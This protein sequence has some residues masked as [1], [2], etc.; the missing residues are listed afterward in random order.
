MFI[1]KILPVFKKGSGVN[2]SMED[3]YHG[4]DALRGFAMIM[5]IVIHG[6]LAYM[7]LSEVWWPSDEKSS[8]SIAVIFAFIHL[9]RMPLFFVLAGFFAKLVITRKSITAWWKNRLIHIGLP[10]FIFSFLMSLL[11]PWILAYGMGGEL[12]LFHSWAGQPFHLWFLYHLLL[13]AFITFIFRIPYILGVKFIYPVMTRFKML[14]KLL[15]AGS[16]LPVG[17]ILISTIVNLKTGGELISN[18]LGS[19]IYFLFGYILY[20]DKQLL[21]SMKSYWSY[22]LVTAFVICA[23]YLLCSIYGIHL[24]QNAAEKQLFYLIIYCLNITSTVFFIYGFIGLAERRFGTYNPKLRFIADSS[25]WMYLIHLP[26]IMIITILTFQLSIPVELKW[27][28][29]ITLA[30]MICLFTYYYLVRFTVISILL[31][32]KKYDRE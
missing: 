1:V 24:A 2:S 31:S 15:F 16:V 18:P 29:S 6:S 14:S 21:E 10:L 7:P 13:F 4:L 9:W 25:Y 3:R 20:E 28:L 32:G 26:I 30:T 11:M 22:Y 23:S 17:F 19:G 5:G 8:N 27:F 12:E